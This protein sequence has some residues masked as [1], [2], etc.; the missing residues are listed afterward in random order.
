[1]QEA[2]YKHDSWGRRELCVVHQE[3][4]CWSCCD[5]LCYGYSTTHYC[6]SL[7]SLFQ[8]STTNTSR[9]KPSVVLN[10]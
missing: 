9:A 3:H 4:H 8:P 10:T 6:C 1:M 5:M 7:T 2:A